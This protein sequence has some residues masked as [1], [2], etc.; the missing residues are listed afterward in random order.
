MRL[1]IPRDPWFWI[2]VVIGIGLRVAPLLIW[3]WASDDCTR[4]ECIYKIAARPIL[5]GKGLG[6]A[7][8]GWLPAPLYPY[9]LAAM[10]TAFG[11]FESIKWFQCAL[12]APLLWIMY[13]LGRRVGGLRG[14]RWMALGMAVHPTFVFFAGTMWTETFY[15]TLLSASVL[16]IMWARDGTGQ[17]AV[18]PGIVLGL[19]VLL[20]GV[21]TYLAPLY[22]LTLLAPDTGVLSPD[23]WRESLKRRKA[24]AAPFLAALLLSIAPYSMAASSRWNGFVVS[25]ATLGHVIALGN[26]D[27]P[28]V[29]FDYGIGQLTGRIYARTLQ[30]GRGDCPRGR[31]PIAHDR[32]E[33]DRATAW[34]ADHPAEFVRRIPTRLAQLF[35]PHSFLTR[36]VRWNYWPGL[37]W[38]AKEILVLFQAFTT[39]L[40]VGFGTFVGIARSRGPWSIMVAGT[41]AYHVAI[42]AIVYGLTRFR[43]PLEPLWMLYIAAW[44]GAPGQPIRELRTQPIRLAVALVMTGILCAL[45]SVY[46]WTGF[47]GW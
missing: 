33:V 26:D 4:D 18:V 19:C 42:I 29:T 39:I 41:I 44:L 3:G 10:H 24:H 34:I 28:P 8:R 25:D 36:H 2:A 46:F 7:P 21:A 16:A 22:L 32:C 38:A 27:Y 31:G 37:P 40:I 14:A 23:A 17:R 35:N 6:L 12:T 13:E 45:M 15:T 20:R 5:E 43:I 30:S 1:S 9:A 11:S 47:P